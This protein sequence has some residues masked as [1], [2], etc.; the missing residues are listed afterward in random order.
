MHAITPLTSLRSMM[1]AVVTVPTRTPTARAASRNAS[2]LRR[3][4]SA[5]NV[6]SGS[7]KM[8]PILPGYILLTSL[9]RVAPEASAAGRSLGEEQLGMSDSNRSSIIC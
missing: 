7:S 5:L 2:T 1:P 8:V 4:F 9:H 6:P 3:H